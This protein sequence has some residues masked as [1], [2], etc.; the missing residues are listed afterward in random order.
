VTVALDASAILAVIFGE[1]GAARVAEVM[2]GAVVS[3]VNLAEVV[4]RMVDAGYPETDIRHRLSLLGLTVRSFDGD[5]AMRNGFLR[6]AT[7]PRGLSLGDRACLALAQREGVRVMTA[8]R[9]WAQLALGVP[10]EVIR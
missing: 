3:A 1:D 7:R 10:I 2:R 9:V 8:D 5:T 4:A 6:A